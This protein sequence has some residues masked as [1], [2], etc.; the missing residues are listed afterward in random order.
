MSIHL[1]VLTPTLALPLA[2]LVWLTVGG[3][4]PAYANRFGPPWQSRVVVDNATLYTQA[5]SG[6]APVGPLTRGA[7][8]VVVAESTAADGTAWTQTPDG[9]I[10]S[11]QVSEDDQPWIA[12]V[13]IP[14]VSIYARP[15]TKEPIRRTAR[16]GD[17][18]RVT[19]A[20]PGIEGDTSVWWSTTEGYVSL[21]SLRESTTDWA[22]G[23]TLPA[24]DAAPNGWWGTFRSQANVRA[25][26][27]T[28]A[29]IV[30]TLGPGVR[31]KVLSQ[32]TGDAVSGNTTWYMIDGGRYAGAVVHSSLV[33]RMPPP[34]QVVV[35]RPADAPAGVG[36]IV[37]SRAAS[38]LTYL[39]AN[40][41]PQFTTYV[42]LGRAGVETPEGEYST[43]GKYRYDN[44]SSANVAGADHDYYLPNVPFVQ[45][46]L[47]GGYAIHGTYWHDQFGLTESQ[48]CINVTWTDGEYLFGLTQPQ[49]ADG[50]NA[51]WATGDLVATPVMIVK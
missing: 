31:V 40:N 14:S 50:D 41:Q 19:G 4:T 27:S 17:L 15:S 28:K 13:T 3:L 38:S 7:L 21:R 26:A 39:D 11:Q 49:V 34:K 2:L 9:W 18:L 51:R 30:G 37:V 47:D 36:T 23:W 10:P 42:S 24:A 25:A 43:M 46:Y 45:Y 1:R 16:Q 33:T 12:E 29:P 20:S 32:V 6:S 48:G 5:D 35:D 22:K 8:L 44:M